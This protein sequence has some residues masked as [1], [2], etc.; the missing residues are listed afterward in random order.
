MC[1]IDGNTCDLYVYDNM[2]HILSVTYKTYL[3][4]AV[5]YWIMM[6][7]TFDNKLIITL[8]DDWKLMGTS[9]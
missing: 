4:T 9:T 2:V 3:H 8:H 5:G 1:Y 6:D 7:L